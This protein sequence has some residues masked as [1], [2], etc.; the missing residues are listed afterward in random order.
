MTLYSLT[1]A[2]R[3]L[4][5]CSIHKT[6]TDSWPPLKG[7]K[8]AERGS[9]AETTMVNL[10]LPVFAGGTREIIQYTHELEAQGLCPV[11]S[12]AS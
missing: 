1:F 9:P 4:K 3:S 2:D 10:V 8:R 5:V 11:K 6:L 7:T 12:G